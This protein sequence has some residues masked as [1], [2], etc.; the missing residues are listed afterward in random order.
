MSTMHM[1]PL[2]FVC[3]CVCVCVVWCMSTM[4]ASS[5]I[6]V[7]VVWCGVFVCLVWGVCGVVVCPLCTCVLSCLC[8]CLCVCVC[9]V[10]VHYARVLSRLC[11]SGVVWCVSLCV[12][13]GL[14]VH[15]ACVLSRLCVCGVMWYVCLCVSGVVCVSTMH[16]SSR[17]YVY[18]W[19]GMCV[20]GVVWCISTMHMYPLM[21]VCLCVHVVC[22]CVWCG[23]CAH[24]AWVLS[25][26]CVCVWCGVAVYYAHVSCHVCVC[27]CVCVC[28]GV[29]G[30]CGVCLV[31]CVCV[32]VVCVHYAHAYSR[33]YV[34]GVVWCGVCMLCV[35]FPPPR[36]EWQVGRTQDGAQPATPLPAVALG[37]EGRVLETCP[38]DCPG[39]SVP[40]SHHPSMPVPQLTL[41]LF[42]GSTSIIPRSRLWQS[43]GMKWGMWKTPR[44]TFSSSWRRLS[45]SKGR[46]PCMRNDGTPYTQ[47]SACTRRVPKRFTRS[48]T[49]LATS[50]GRGGA[51]AVSTLQMGKLRHGGIQPFAQDH[52]ALKWQSSDLAMGSVSRT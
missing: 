1:R 17:V 13:C 12:W 50:P 36:L 6:C 40:T 43:G 32:C 23:V 41:S 42:S 28:V 5:S 27:V 29:G 19:C 15:Y 33:V 14:C 11:V 47:S 24:Y 52:L 49:G 10:C 9:G 44:F 7:C 35:V 46:A 25:C 51:G 18:V 3:L 21:F 37:T 4:Y 16:M 45:S 38:H 39:D 34:C 2:L 30:W 31:W 26:L 20:C 48:D 8:V 22:V